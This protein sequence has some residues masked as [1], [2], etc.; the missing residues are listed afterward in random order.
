[1]EIKSMNSMTMQ[2]L[3][4]FAFVTLFSC[5]LIGATENISKKKP[6]HSL[7]ERNKNKIYDELIDA[8]LELCNKYSTF[9][10][11]RQ[12]A[13][14]LIKKTKNYG[15]LQDLLSYPTLFNNTLLHLAL[16]KNCIEVALVLI[17]NSTEK[18]L[19]IPNQQG[20]LAIHIAVTLNNADLITALHEKQSDCFFTKDRQD[21]IPLHYA[22]EKNAL[23]ILDLMLALAPQAIN[24][25]DKQGNTPAHL[26]SDAIALK[27]FQ[28]HEANFAL[29][30]NKGISVQDKLIESFE[31]SS[32]NNFPDCTIL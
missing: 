22:V 29:K 13:S 31:S 30:N 17:A 12:E 19:S 27:I 1:M 11:P 7:S 24:E 16:E 32:K 26:C 3:F 10:S 18:N 5:S 15:L 14:A 21:R 2:S 20:K 4:A 28:N 8:F 25:Q 9:A 6:S 23:A